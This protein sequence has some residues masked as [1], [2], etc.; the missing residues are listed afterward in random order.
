MMLDILATN[1]TAVLRSAQVFRAGFDLL[2][3]L[4]DAGPEDELAEAL[5][6]SR[7]ERRRMFS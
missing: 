3:S 1:R 4:V 6:Q 2:V 5:A 7:N